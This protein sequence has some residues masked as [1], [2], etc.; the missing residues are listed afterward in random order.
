MEM[1]TE[2]IIQK[3]KDLVAKREKLLTSKITIEAE[4]NSRKR[5]LK[6]AIEACK[7]AGYNPDTLAEDIK[8]LKE[9]LNVKLNVFEADLTTAED[10]MKP[11]LKEIG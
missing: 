9:V 5:A 11:M 1:T 6:D 10:L 2:E 4:L 7:S 3:H 8:K